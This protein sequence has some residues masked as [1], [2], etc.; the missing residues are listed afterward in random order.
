MTALAVLPLSISFLYL[1]LRFYKIDETANKTYFP[2]IDSEE[3]TVFNAEDGGIDVVLEFNGD[4]NRD[5]FTN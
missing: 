1:T 2:D 5:K 3:R 4:F